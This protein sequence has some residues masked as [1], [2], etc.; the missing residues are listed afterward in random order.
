MIS[1]KKTT[2]A[3]L[4]LALS[5][6]TISVSSFASSDAARI[7]QKNKLSVQNMELETAKSLSTV[8][9]SLSNVLKD[10]QEKESNDYSEYVGGT[11]ALLAAGTAVLVSSVA[12]KNVRSIR[13]GYDD[14]AAGFALAFVAGPVALLGISSSNILTLLELT[15]EQ[16]ADSAELNKKIGETIVSLSNL[17]KQLTNEKDKKAV[18]NL[19]NSVM[20]VKTAVTVEAK[21]AARKKILL[22]ASFLVSGVTTAILLSKDYRSDLQN[23]LLMLGYSTA[24]ILNSIAGFS[25]EDKDVIIPKVEAAITAVERAETLLK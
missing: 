1:M 4:I 3:A 8:K 7:A 6:Q 14:G 13:A 11:N 24:G 20:E 2:T 15:M 22:G 12:L 17:Q 23:S 21:D 10:L 5:G 18:S 19:I 9:S 25:G 16:R